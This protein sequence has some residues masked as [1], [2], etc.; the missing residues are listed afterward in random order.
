M[1]KS[2]CAVRA[3]RSPCPGFRANCRY[4]GAGGVSRPHCLASL[5][6][7]HAGPGCYRPYGPI[8]R[9]GPGARRAIRWGC[10]NKQYHGV[11]SSDKDWTARCWW[12]DPAARCPTVELL[13]QAAP[14]LAR[15]ASPCPCSDKHVA[16]C[17]CSYFVVLGSWWQRVVVARWNRTNVRGERVYVEH[18]YP[19][20]LV[21]TNERS[22]SRVIHNLGTT[23]VKGNLG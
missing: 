7:G 18:L 3:S 14:P 12:L 21:R 16:P 10:C 8:W 22:V 19:R 4:R 23:P 1:L 17:S 5:S 13:Q 9:G 11:A 2:D 15:V 6:M 20:T